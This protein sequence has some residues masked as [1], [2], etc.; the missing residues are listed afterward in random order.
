M[1][2]AY[3]ASY[4]EAHSVSCDVLDLD[5]VLFTESDD[6]QKCLWDIENY[7]R[8]NEEALFSVT[9]SMFRD[10]V[11]ALSERIAKEKYL[12][13]GFSLTGSNLLFTIALTRSI[14]ARDESI[15]IVY[16]GPTI[17]FCHYGSQRPFRFLSSPVTGELLVDERLVDF[18]VF[19]EGEKALLDIVKARKAK[20]QVKNPGVVT[21]SVLPQD[22][23]PPLIENLDDLPFPAWE[24]FPLDQYTVR[25]ELPILFSRGCVNKCAFCNDWIIWR[26]KYRVRSAK[27]IFLEMKMMSRRFG[28]CSFR[29]NDLMFNGNLKMLDELAGLLIAEGLNIKWGAQGFIRTDMTDHF[30]QRMKRAGLTDIVYG[31]ESLS[32]NVLRKMRKPFNY[33]DVLLVLTRTKA[34]GIGAHINLIVGFPGETEQDHLL[35]QQRLAELTPVL[36]SVANINCCRLMADSVIETS[37]DQFDIICQPKADMF[38]AWET[39]DGLNNLDIRQRRMAEL[40][41]AIARIGIKRGNEPSRLNRWRAVWSGKDLIS[42]REKIFCICLGVGIVF[43]FLE[44]LLRLLGFGYNLY[45]RPSADQSAGFRILCIGESTTW[46]LGA[47]DPLER[48]YPHQLESLLNTKYPG[49]R[50]QCF[51]ENAIGQNTS[52]ILMKLPQHIK[53]IQPDMVIMMVGA[54]NVWN[55]DSSNILLFGKTAF[56]RWSLETMIFLDSFRVWKLLKNIAFSLGSY[57]ERWDYYFPVDGISRIDRN[58]RLIGREVFDRLAEY[59]MQEMLRTFKSNGIKVLMCTYPKESRALWIIKHGLSEK[60]GVFFVDNDSFFRK[61]SPEEDYFWTDRW[62][63]NDRGYQILAENIF[64]VIV[65]NRMIEAK[66]E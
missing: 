26:G 47:T 46:G 24:K 22:L 38:D 60:Y 53:E 12:V 8:W 19:G 45:Y 32:D 49:K 27:N 28:R 4:L 23:R 2:M 35:T 5:A 18:I 62:H 64:S 42:L 34:A 31:V 54:N 56:N 20:T 1:G 9:I 58:D 13:V 48:G 25:E 44:L 21:L 30:F 3:I 41:D 51:F 55:M 36:D 50:I 29:C 66:D 43:V 10:Q 61:L 17:H 59:D 7:S 6:G 37:F 14:K 15:C 52:E 57:R 11:E 65:T 16:G 33:E 40:K 63:P 39:A